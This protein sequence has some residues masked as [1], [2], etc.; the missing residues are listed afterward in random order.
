VTFPQARPTSDHKR[1][2]IE[3]LGLSE[4]L[5]ERCL[6]E[7]LSAGE[8]TQTFILSRL[9]R[10][11]WASTSPWSSRPAKASASAAASASF[12]ASAP[13]TPT[14]TTSRP[15]GCCAPRAPRPSSPAPGQGAD[16]RL[17][18]YFR[19]AHALPHCRRHRRRGSRAKLL[20]IQRADKLHGI[21]TR[22]SPRSAR[23]SATSFAASCRSL[24]RHV[25]E[26]YPA[27]A[28]PEHL[29]HREGCG[30]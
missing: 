18:P 14:P 6:G 27:L 4:R 5:M 12:P 3:K 17:P 24:R 23:A 20:L 22:A 1:Y 7:A 10:H 26:R 11:R 30:R 9:P 15:T 19:R 16:V 25:C 8:T 21:S 2:F 29:C 28:P 13:A